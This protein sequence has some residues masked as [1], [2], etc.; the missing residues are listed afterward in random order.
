MHPQHTQYTHTRTDVQYST[1]CL[2]VFLRSFLLYSKFISFFSNLCALAQIIKQQ[3]QMSVE[4]VDHHS[5]TT[6]TMAA[7]HTL[8]CTVHATQRVSPYYSNHSTYFRDVY[9]V[10]CKRFSLCGGEV[11]WRSKVYTQISAFGVAI[12]PSGCLL[13]WGLSCMGC[14]NICQPSV[15]I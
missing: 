13:W 14:V 11:R 1:Y 6:A 9:F 10:C 7:M 8:T 2:F 15:T 5:L 12:P 3:S 4:P